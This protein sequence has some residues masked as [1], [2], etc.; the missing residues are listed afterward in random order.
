MIDK[1][2][3]NLKFSRRATVCSTAI[4]FD[5]GKEKL[6]RPCSIAPPRASTLPARL[7]ATGMQPKQNDATL[8]AGPREIAEPHRPILRRFANTQDRSAR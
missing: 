5:A 2:A 6:S 8:A 3:A 7:Q 1:P 4:F